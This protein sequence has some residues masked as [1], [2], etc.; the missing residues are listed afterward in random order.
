MG[1]D[2]MVDLATFLQSGLADFTSQIDAETK[3]PVG[4]DPTHGQELFA[5]CA[6]CHGDDGRLLNFGSDDE[7]EYVGTIALDNPWEFLHKVRSGQPGTAMP[8]AMDGDWTLGDLLDLLAF[9]QT[10]PVVAP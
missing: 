10:L 1:D 8:A 7:P 4:A 2:A 5:A 3:S 6:A 9:A